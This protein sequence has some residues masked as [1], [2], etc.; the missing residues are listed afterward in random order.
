VAE[1][2]SFG[3][4]VYEVSF[5]PLPGEQLKQFRVSLTRVDFA[6]PEKG[7]VPFEE[8]GRSDSPFGPGR[9]GVR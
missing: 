6:G 7:W 2:M 3:I 8:R 1:F 9:T 5:R 4:Y